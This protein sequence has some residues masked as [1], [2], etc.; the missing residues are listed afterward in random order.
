[1]EIMSR[2][3]MTSKAKVFRTAHIIVKPIYIHKN[4]L[5]EAK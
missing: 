4:T 1:M 5:L 2:N 3:A